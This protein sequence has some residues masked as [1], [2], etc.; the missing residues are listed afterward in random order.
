MNEARKLEKEL[1]RRN[2]ANEKRAVERAA[3]E[4][5]AVLLDGEMVSL[6]P[7]CM[8]YEQWSSY[9]R[10]DCVRFE[11]VEAGVW[12]LWTSKGETKL[13]LVIDRFHLGRGER[14][15]RNETTLFV[16]TPSPVPKKVDEGTQCEC[17]GM[18][19]AYPDE[20][21]AIVV[22]DAPIRRVVPVDVHFP[23]EYIEWDCKTT[24][25]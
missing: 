23:H 5:G 18:P 9:P 4:L 7:P 3:A 1:S 14:L 22:D 10:F 13:A 11:Q 12:R 19:R 8:G 24:A 21:I 2:V 17:D 6:P 15:A 25:L 16:L 20:T